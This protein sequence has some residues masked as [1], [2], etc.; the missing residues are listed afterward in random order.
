MLAKKFA[1]R[2]VGLIRGR[3]VV[4]ETMA[5]ELDRPLEAWGVEG[6]IGAG[7]DDQP[8]RNALA[9][10]AGYSPVVAARHHVAALLRRG[11]VVALADQDQGGNGHVAFRAKAFWIERDRGPALVLGGF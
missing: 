3:F 9:A 11:P 2:I 10:R 6:V 1:Q 5:E 8:H 7:I 4:F